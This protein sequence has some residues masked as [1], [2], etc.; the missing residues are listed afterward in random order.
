M[1]QSSYTTAQN[2][3][4][5]LQIISEGNIRTQEEVVQQQGSTNSVADEIMKFKELLDKGVITQEEF[6]AKKKQLLNL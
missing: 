5:V 4:S 1:Y 2:I 6:E 3:L